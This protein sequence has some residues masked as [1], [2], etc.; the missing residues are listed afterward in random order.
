MRRSRTPKQRVWLGPGRYRRRCRDALTNRDAQS[1]ANSNSNP[2]SM[3]ADDDADT[4]AHA[5]GYGYSCRYSHTHSNSDTNIYSDA[6][7]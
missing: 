4:Y 5:Y 3:R 6:C 2:C 7:R 1:Y